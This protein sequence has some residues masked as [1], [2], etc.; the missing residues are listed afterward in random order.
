VEGTKLS[1]VE[2]I[3]WARFP[4]TPVTQVG[5]MEAAVVLSSVIAVKV[6]LPAL[7]LVEPELPVTL[8]EIGFV[9]VRLARVPT[10]VRLELRTFD[11][12][13]VPVM[14]DA[15]TEL[16]APAVKLDAVPVRPVPAPLNELPVITPEEVI[17]PQA[18]VP[19]RLSAPP[20]GAI[21]KFP[22]LETVNKL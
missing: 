12:S 15:A 2:E 22:A 10:L 11:A 8:P 13:V 6:A 17:A 7:P 20:F 3:F 4:E 1:F 18:N 5:N 19:V 14:F 9:T 21:V 16:A